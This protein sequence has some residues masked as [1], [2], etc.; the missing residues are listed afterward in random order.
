M[1]LSL[2]D[3][4]NTVIIDIDLEDFL[5]FIHFFRGHSTCP[6]FSLM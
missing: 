2:L 3:V 5:G 1:Q 4:L 6:T